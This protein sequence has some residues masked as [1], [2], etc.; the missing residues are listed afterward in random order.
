MKAKIAL[1]F[2]VLFLLCCTGVAQSAP[3]AGLVVQGTDYDSATKVTIVHLLNTS[4]KEITAFEL[5]IRVVQP[6]GTLGAAGNSVGQDLL[7][8]PGIAPGATRDEKVTQ[9]GEVRASVSMVVYSD[10][11]A[12]TTNPYSVARIMSERQGSVDGMQKVNEILAKNMTSA[13]PAQDAAR[14]LQQELANTTDATS[15][16]YRAQLQIAI[17]N[18]SHRQP[19][20][21]AELRAMS[22]VVEG[23][24]EEIVKVSAHTQLK[25]VAP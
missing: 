23:H 8:Q 16:S 12:E 18:L 24:K 2:A 4:K 6:D 5:A 25:E 3:I 15:A 22:A 10:D 14:E 9:V 1:F 13:N 21:A 19:D 7:G 17:K 11:T 20:R